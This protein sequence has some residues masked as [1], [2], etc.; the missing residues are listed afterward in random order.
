LEIPSG[1]SSGSV[2]GEDC[3]TGTELAEPATEFAAPVEL[4]GVD[5]MDSSTGEPVE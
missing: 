3:E 2:V 5:T 1:V 4:T